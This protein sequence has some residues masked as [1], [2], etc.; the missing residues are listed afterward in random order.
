M[1]LT[2]ILKGQ[3]NF[4]K[5]KKYQQTRHIIEIVVLKICLGFLLS[6]YVGYVSY[7]VVG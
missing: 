4:K 6:Y 2:L 3:Q 1:G 7:R 5:T